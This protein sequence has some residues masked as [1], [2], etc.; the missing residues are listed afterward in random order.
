MSESK[1][2][3]T[4]PPGGKRS[5]KDKKVNV[6][7]VVRMR[8]PSEQEHAINNPTVVS[9]IGMTEMA[10]RH[11]SS[12]RLFTFDRVFGQYANQEE[13]YTASVKPLVEEVLSGFNCTVFAYGQTGTGKTHTMEGDISKKDITRMSGVIPRAVHTIFRELEKQEAAEYSVKVSFLELYNEELADLLGLEEN[14]SQTL[15]L[16]EGDKGLAIPGLEE[17]MAGSAADVFEL[18]RKAQAARHTA[19]TLMN[20]NSS[21]SHCVFTLTVHTK[22]T[23]IDGQDIIKTGKLH[24]VDLAGSECVARSGAKGERANEAGNINKSLLTLGRVINALV[25]RLPHVPYRDSKLTRLLAESLGGTSKTVVIATVSP[26]AISVDESMNTLDYA[27]RAKNIKNKPQANKMMTRQAYMKEVMAE[28]QALKRENEVLRTRNGVILPPEQYEQLK[29]DVKT[30]TAL[31]TELETILQAKMQEV[32]EVAGMYETLT[33]EHEE[34]SEANK[35]LQSAH[36][37][38][39][40]AMVHAQEELEVKVVELEEQT[41]LVQH[42]VQ[43]E[44]ALLDQA[45]QTKANLLEAQDE[46]HRLHGKVEE[47]HANEERTHAQLESYKTSTHTQLQEWDARMTKFTEDHEV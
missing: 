14:A 38:A 41:H 18:L 13:I 22:Q 42:H 31:V 19:E 25:D 27:N 32:D 43:T 46:A 6:Q 3:L 20:K 9:T 35:E 4:A 39:K 26:C 29:E 37:L 33:A 15:K 34:L 5:K 2:P 16:L 36:A 44:C 23:T 28:M 1:R 7:V 45:E 10:I 47:M 40:E 8:P 21:R 17:V 12:R 11:K 24:M 30:K